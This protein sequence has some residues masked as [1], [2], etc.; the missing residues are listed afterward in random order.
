MMRRVRYYCLSPSLCGL[1]LAVAC[2]FAPQGVSAIPA[3]S[4]PKQ[5]TTAAGTKEIQALMDSAER[6][7]VEYRAD[8]QLSA[9][10]SGKLRSNRLAAETLER[11]YRD[12]RTA[13]YPYKQKN[14]LSIPNLLSQKLTTAFGLNLDSLSIKTRVIRAM[15]RLDP[16]R[17][18]QMLE[19]IRFDIPAA[20]CT[21]PMVYDV[22][23]FYVMLDALLRSAFQTKE[24]QQGDDLAFLDTQVRNLNYTAQLAPMATL[25]ARAEVSNA[26][27]E[28][29]ISEFSRALQRI[30]ATD[31][32]LG[33]MER[34]QSLRKA[35]SLVAKR[36]AEPAPSSIGL[37]QAYRSFLVRSSQSPACS[38]LSADKIGIVEGYNRLLQEFGVDGSVSGLTVGDLKTDRT[39]GLAEIERLPVPS[40]FG[41]LFG[42]LMERRKRQSMQG[43]QNG[44]MEDDEWELDV[45]DFLSKIEALDPAKEKCRGCVFHEKADLLLVFLDF[46]PQGKLKERLVDHTVRFL[47]TDTMQDDRPLEWLFRVKLLLNLSRKP[48]EEQ[49]KQVA[50]LQKEGKLLTMLPS[51]AGPEILS[52]MKRSKNTI[53]YLYAIA[54]AILENEY[55]S[56]PYLTKPMN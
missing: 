4:S 40:E 44:T 35:L 6:L 34:D 26:H 29:L 11:L 37:V 25:I 50:E 17:A 47:A 30:K 20:P 3:Q 32:E 18:R 39:D 52:A 28:G 9:I 5:A 53:L 8:I 38:D 12:A 54:D 56:P 10:E 51:D 16:I 46:T 36:L 41:S 45:T 49:R 15:L 2:A 43:S 33:A 14:V 55:V 7:A 13:K 48:S 19:E 24:K 1:V 22:S 31:R 27:L 42:R 23:D 21:S